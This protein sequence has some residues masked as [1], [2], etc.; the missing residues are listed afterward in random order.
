MVWFEVRFGQ[1]VS[2]GGKPVFGQNLAAFFTFWFITFFYKDIL[3]KIFAVAL[4]Q[5]GGFKMVYCK[6]G[7]AA[8]PRRSLLTSVRKS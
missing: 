8:W 4:H 5:S 7:C 2:R 6:L 3:K 1:V